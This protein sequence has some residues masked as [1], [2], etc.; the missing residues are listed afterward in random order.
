MDQAEENANLPSVQTVVPEEPHDTLPSTP[1]PVPVLAPVAEPIL[2]STTV[3][4]PTHPPTQV[5]VP[6][7]ATVAPA[8]PHT[9]AQEPP[10]MGALL[11]HP[12]LR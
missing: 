4:V 2:E 3:L 9:Q 11:G 7:P 12:K 5:H 6:N 8:A 1:V 10:L